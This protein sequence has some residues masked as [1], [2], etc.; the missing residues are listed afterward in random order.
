MFGQIS[1]GI[2]SIATVAAA[3][4]MCE[5]ISGSSKSSKSI[6]RAVKL[7]CGLCICISVFSVFISGFGEISKTETVMPDTEGISSCSDVYGS[8]GYIINNTKKDLE[9][10]LSDNI[11]AKYGIKPISVSIQFNIKKS[12]CETEVNISDALIILPSSSGEEDRQK[13]KSYSEQA[14]G[15]DVSVKGAEDE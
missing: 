15:C 10:R 8:D 7:V 6:E 11:F 9:R 3:A 4:I 14:L 5:V 13:V 12:D 1:E 2:L